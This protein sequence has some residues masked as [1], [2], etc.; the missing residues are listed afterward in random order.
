MKTLIL[1]LSHDGQT[2]KI[3]EFIQSFIDDEVVIEPL[4]EDVDIRPFERVIIGAAIRYGHFNRLLYRFVEKNSSLLND[5]KAIFFGVNLTA[6]KPGKDNPETNP[7]IRKFLQRISWQPSK[8]AIFAGALCY[9]RY[10]WFDRV[11]IQL[12]MKITGGETDA[13]K[14]IEYTNWEKVKAFAESLN[15]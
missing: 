2:K 15:P 11:M 5:R 8:I 4:R 14:E 9:P 1:Y 3:A 6:R 13:T 7:Y 12:I 10:K